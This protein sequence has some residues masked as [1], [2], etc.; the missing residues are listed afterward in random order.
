MYPGHCYQIVSQYTCSTTSGAYSQVNVE[1]PLPAWSMS[2]SKHTRT[3]EQTTGA[4][5]DSPPP[6]SDKWF[7]DPKHLQPTLSSSDFRLPILWGSGSGHVRRSPSLPAADPPDIVTHRQESSGAPENCAKIVQIYWRGVA[8]RAR[9][10]GCASIFHSTLEIHAEKREKN[11]RG[12]KVNNADSLRLWLPETASRVAIVVWRG[13]RR[14]PRR[15]RKGGARGRVGGRASGVGSPAPSGAGRRV[16]MWGHRG[17]N[18]RRGSRG[19]T[20]VPTP[21]HGGVVPAG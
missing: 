7:S 13:Q 12:S 3:D 21:A 11:R 2:G 16:P 17:E 8:W 9:L 19:T 14:V 18:D 20:A 4:R 10:R 15:A 6:P 1:R 5:P